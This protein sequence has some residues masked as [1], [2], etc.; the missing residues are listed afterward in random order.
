MEGEMRQSF[1]R[2][3]ISCPVCGKKLSDQLP[4]VEGVVEE[5]LYFSEYVRIVS[6]VVTVRL[7]FGHDRDEEN[8]NSSLD[9][10]HL[11]VAVIKL[12]FDSSGE[13]TGFNIL[14]VLP[15]TEE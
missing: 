12:V 15:Q 9:K 13:C 3:S 5:Q 10:P 14:D 6:S 7:I 4:C 2:V 8:E 11:L 1:G